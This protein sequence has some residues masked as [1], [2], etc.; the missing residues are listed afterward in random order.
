MKRELM[1]AFRYTR[2]REVEVVKVVSCAL[3]LRKYR[4]DSPI[5][6]F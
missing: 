4:Q 3:Y 5:S 1:V 6:I 2:R